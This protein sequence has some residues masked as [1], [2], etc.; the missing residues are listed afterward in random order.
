MKID[1]VVN[2]ARVKVSHAHALASDAGADDEQDKLTEGVEMVREA[3][4][5]LQARMSLSE[6]SRRLPS[7]VLLQCDSG[8]VLAR[9]LQQVGRSVPFR[10]LGSVRP[11]DP[12][13]LNCRRPTSS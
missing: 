12:L 5:L 10:R 7:S 1:D 4:R 13:L 8:R 2:A 11:I 9:A 6:C 3:Q